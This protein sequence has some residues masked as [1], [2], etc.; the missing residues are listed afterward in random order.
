MRGYN[1]G[2]AGRSLIKKA[3]ADGVV[4]DS[5]D[6][7]KEIIRR[8]E[9]REITPEQGQ[10]ELRKIKRDAKKNGMVTRNQAFNGVKP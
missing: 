10:A 1:E 2:M 7:R 6:V 5:M 8:I 4:A 3:E 9:S